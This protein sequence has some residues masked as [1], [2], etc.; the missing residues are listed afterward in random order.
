MKK[1][2]TIGN[3]VIGDGHPCFLIAEMSGNHNLDFSR[4]VD[5]VVAAKNAGVDAIKLQTYTAD[6]I[7]LKADSPEFYTEENG[8]WSGKTLYELYEEAYTPWEWVPKLKK[9]ADELDI[10]LFSSPFDETAVD[11]LEEVNLPAYKIASFEINDIGLLRKVARTGKPIFISTGIADLSD[12]NLA[13]KTC[14]AE[15]NDQIIL[16]K[17]TSA[18]PAPYEQM[19]LRMIQNMK[20]TFQCN[21]GLSDHSLGD[22]AAIAAVAMGAAVVEK[23]FTLR[24]DDGGV[25]AAFSMEEL[26]MK[27]M[28]SRIRNVEAA[29]GSIS[30]E[31]SDAQLSEKRYSRSLYAAKFIGKG[32]IITQDNVRSVR[33]NFGLHTKYFDA[34][35]GKKATRDIPYATALSF[36]DIDWREE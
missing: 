28:V 23:H 18:Y 29:L 10:I 12:I 2:I 20:E 32:E 19:N 26:E 13:I 8:L 16:L 5:I 21:V 24:R 11:F 4:A 27:Q 14:L 9:L 3:K 6:T 30:Y 1:S 35:I 36:A 31:L 15:G 34:I 22:E 33:P 17:C 7:T 25:D